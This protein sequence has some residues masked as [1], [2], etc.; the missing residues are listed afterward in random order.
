[1]LGQWAIFK[2]GMSRNF[3]HPES[4]SDNALEDKIQGVLRGIDTKVETCHRLQGKGWVK[5]GSS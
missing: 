3:R 5:E 4:V 1:M 2:E